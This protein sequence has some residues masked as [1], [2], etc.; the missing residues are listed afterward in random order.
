[1]NPVR[2][3]LAVALL[4]GGSLVGG[5]AGSMLVRDGGANV[6]RAQDAAR[7][8][9]QPQQG[10]VAERPTVSE[11]D[12]AH[13]ETLATVFRKVG[14][15]IEPSVV[16]INVI[17]TVTASRPPAYDDMLR[18]FFPDGDG[19]GQPD[20]PEGFGPPSGP[21]GAPGA[22]REGREPMQQGTGSGVIMEV[23]GSDAYILT[24]NHVAGGATE[25]LVTLADGRRIDNGTVVGTDPKTDL[26]IIKV[27]AD[28]LVA[29]PWGDSDKLE[30]GDWI[31]AFGSPFG[32]VGSMTHGIVSALNRRAGILGTNG[33]E[34]FIQVDAPINPGNSGGP[35]VNVR[36]EVVGINTAIASRNGGFQGIGFAIP[37]NQAKFVYGAL[38]SNGKVVRGWLG[39]KI[40]DV[41]ERPEL[42]RSFGYEQ[43]D[44]VLVEETF[45]NTPATG[46]LQAGDIVTALAGRPVRNTQE[47]RNTVAATP[48][49]TDL[50]MTVFRDGK[51]QE[52]T[53]RIA[54]QPEDMTVAAAGRPSGDPAARPTTEDSASVMGMKLVTPDEKTAQRFELGETRQGALVTEV[55]PKSAA[56][57]AGLAAGM[58]ITRVGPKDVLTAK[59]AADA[60]NEQGADNKGVRLY[61]TSPEG[62]Q[63]VFVKPATAK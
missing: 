19:D 21:P 6:A 34:N 48:P 15:T 12:L 41:S 22:P 44:G 24:N 26:A 4:A 2:K 3:S 29:A 57:R 46:K 47:L 18:R 35:L 32:Y 61:V 59:Q 63:F 45:A 5:F 31:M 54:E 52:V 53:I 23:Q 38:K 25:I 56:A 16:N 13:V 43:R 58:V 49:G 55:D 27:Q 28:G 11:Q 14:K 50:T 40:G 1:M 8:A 51:T 36:G 39:V 33:Y 60:I 10:N 62:S 7:D 20:L 9:A 37:S 17:K 42:A 30:K